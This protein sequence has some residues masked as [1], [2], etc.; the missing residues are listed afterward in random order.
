MNILIPKVTPI[1]LFTLG[2]LNEYPECRVYHFPCKPAEHELIHR[3]NP[4]A[5]ETSAAEGMNC[6]LIDGDCDV[7]HE[8]VPFAIIIDHN[9]NTI[10]SKFAHY[11]HISVPLLY[12]ELNAFDFE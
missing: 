12:Q 1:S 5:I 11:C 8:A 10:H 9:H 4:L 6:A 7:L 3:I 2:G